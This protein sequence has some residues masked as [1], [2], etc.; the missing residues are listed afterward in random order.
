MAGGKTEIGGHGREI[1]GQG[2]GKRGKRERGTYQGN[3]LGEKRERREL[4][5]EP[6][7]SDGRARRAGGANEWRTTCSCALFLGLLG[8]GFR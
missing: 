3:R 5:G 8:L 4:T 1:G 6:A 2:W 7:V